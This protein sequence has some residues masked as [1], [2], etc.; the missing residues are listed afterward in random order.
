MHIID[1]L[2]EK[3]LGGYHILIE[4]DVSVF[5]HGY[6]SVCDQFIEN[7][8]NPSAKYTSDT[9]RL[10]VDLKASLLEYL[11]LMVG[12]VVFP[13]D[14]K[15]IIFEEPQHTGF[16]LT[17]LLNTSDQYPT[18]VEIEKWK[19]NLYVLNVHDVLISVSI[20]GS[21]IPNSILH[22]LIFYED[23]EV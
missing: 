21:K 20:N 4:S 15:K 2:N 7:Y 6:D 22:D 10:S 12:V 14:L 17:V 9:K 3:I 18:D 5:E 16:F 13:D 1:R 11:D 23:K 19:Y 8:S